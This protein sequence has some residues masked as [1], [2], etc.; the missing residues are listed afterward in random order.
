MN[1][2]NVQLGDVGERFAYGD[3]V[4]LKLATGP[5]TSA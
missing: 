5:F 4:G 3:P 1:N 2:D